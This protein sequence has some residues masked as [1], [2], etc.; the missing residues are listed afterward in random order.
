MVSVVVQILQECWK[1]W[2]IEQSYLELALW[3]QLR[4]FFLKLLHYH[5]KAEY[6]DLVCR[7]SVVYCGD[8]TVQ[9]GVARR[10]HQAPDMGPSI[11]AARPALL[12]PLMLMSAVTRL[13]CGLQ[14]FNHFEGFA[15]LIYRFAVDRFLEK[16]LH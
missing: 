13:S 15:T 3:R 6:Y 12:Y 4:S 14:S 2:S 16:L 5:E 11:L 8:S 9:N 10:G 1:D 7:P